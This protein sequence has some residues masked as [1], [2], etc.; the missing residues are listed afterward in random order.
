ETMGTNLVLR[1]GGNHALMQLAPLSRKV[2]WNRELKQPEPMSARERD[3][4]Q[5]LSASLPSNGKS[6]RI[7]G[8]LLNGS[9]TLENGCKLVLEVREFKLQELK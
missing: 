3:A 1:T 4:F 6:V 5:A 8:P 9:K 2:Q 7:T